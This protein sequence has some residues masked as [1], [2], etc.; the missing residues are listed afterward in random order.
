LAQVAFLYKGDE[1]GSLRLRAGLDQLLPVHGARLWSDARASDPGF[2]AELVE[3]L[4]RSD[5]I[6][7][8]VGQKGL[9]RYQQINELD[10]TVDAL[11]ARR[12][13]RLIIALLG[14]AAPPTE[15]ALFDPFRD[16]TT[17]VPLDADDPNALDVIRLALPQAMPK[18]NTEE[19]R[20]GSEVVAR[21]LRA[22]PQQ[23]SLTLIFS[24]YAF[25][26]GAERTATPA[27]AIRQFLRDRDLRGFLPWFDTMGSIARATDTTDDD[28]GSA[29]A[30]AMDA[31]P[32]VG[33][34]GVYLRLV[35]ANWVRMPGKGRLFIVSCGPDLRLDLALR[36]SAMP[37]QHL[38]VVHCPL[39]P[40]EDHRLLAQRVNIV[41][42]RARP[43]L[44]D[45]PMNAVTDDDRV[46]LI[47]PFG[48]LEQPGK[49][50]LTAEQWRESSPGMTLPN[51]VANEMTRSFL[52]VIG[53]GAF[54]PSLQILFKVLLRE[55][56]AR[57]NR[58][59]N[60]YLIHN[61][62]ARVAD[63]LY[64]VEAMLVRGKD[65]EN[66]K[67]WLSDT[68]GLQLKLLDLLL[69]LTWL[70]HQLRE[71]PRAAA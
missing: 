27:I 33:P 55:A 71:G 38:R 56:L 32:L 68:Y 36:S 59:S 35:A 41:G 69:F 19:G 66:F 16:R 24:P 44:V 63:P 34:L 9:G 53:A 17:T 65:Q 47:K 4:G 54:S 50:L 40:K 37:V 45:D 31:G 8:C 22:T 1:P 43:D 29:V 51:G 15:F 39:E 46:V 30:R 12:D 42:G 67:T 21:T 13:R 58:N 64:R 57:Q 23:R 18:P 20:F 2:S 60:R 28:A 52:L 11:Q 5:A 10:K 6:V 70:D 3:E 48:C 49:A 25:A 62:N 14:G 61:I 7:H 26:E